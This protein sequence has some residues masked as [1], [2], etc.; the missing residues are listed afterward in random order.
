MS[1]RFRVRWIVLEHIREISI[2]VVWT[3]R[4]VLA[5]VSLCYRKLSIQYMRTL[6]NEQEK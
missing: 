4:T 2:R 1:E 5:S 3:D 6:R